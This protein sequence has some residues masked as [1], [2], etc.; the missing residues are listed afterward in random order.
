MLDLTQKNESV[1]LLAPGSISTALNERDFAI[2]P[3]QDLVIYTLGNYKQTTRTL[4]HMRAIGNNWSAPEILPFSGMYQDIEPFFTPNGAWL[5]FASNR[6]LNKDDSSEDYNIWRVAIN[7]GSFG[8]PEALPIQINTPGDEF[9]P[10]LSEL[11]TLYFT[12][13]RSD[14]IGREDIFMCSDSSGQFGS[15]SVLD[16]AVNSPSFEFNAYI[17]PD[18]SYLLFSSYGRTDG[19]GG[20][21][22]YISYKDR[23]G[24]WQPAMHLENEINSPFL[25]YCP[26]VDVA[27]NM[28]YFTSNR[29]TVR[30]Q[31]IESAQMLRN[32]SNNPING[33]DN[34]YKV[35]M[36]LV[37]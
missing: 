16:S 27:N 28:L 10:S 15:V 25:D 8:A 3:N 11:G 23:N 34:I 1:N 12:A 17:A 35:S 36:E 14:G 6:P 7:G 31:P 33:L 9:Y 20:G 21:D 5:Y 4:V 37:P 30:T 13:T 32:L 2:S 22:L 19:L 29:D 24:I 26:F 18:E